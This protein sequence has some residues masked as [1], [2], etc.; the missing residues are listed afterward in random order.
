MTETSSFRVARAQT[1]FCL[2]WA[3]QLQC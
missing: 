3:W 1:Y 2:S